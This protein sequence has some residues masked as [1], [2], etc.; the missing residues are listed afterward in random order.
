MKG[1]VFLTTIVLFAGTAA[2]LAQTKP[3]GPE[4]FYDEASQRFLIL[5]PQGFKKVQVVVRHP[6]GGRW[7]GDGE[8]QEKQILFAQT[9][10]EDQNRGTYFLAKGGESKWEIGFKPGQREPQDAGINGL[11]RRVSEEKRLQLARKEYQAAEATLDQSLK[12][13]A[14]AAVGP[15]KSLLGQWKDRWP[16]LRDRWVGLVFA[17][18]SAPKP[19]GQKPAPFGAKPEPP[20]QERQADYWFAMA[21]TASRA[22]G[23]V[24][25][26]LDKSRAV[27]W[28]GLYDDG[29]GGQINIRTDLSGKLRIT[30]NFSRG[31]DQ[32]TGALS[33]ETEPAKIITNKD[34]SK[35]AE[36]TAKDVAMAEGTTPA[37]A[38]V[39]LQRAGRFMIVETGNAQKIAG[40]GW[41]DGIYRWAP[42]PK[43]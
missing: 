39:K 29:F 15:D 43:E 13:A 12:A 35:S 14:K 18:P 41:F 3:V 27:D 20:G 36:I 23:F 22:M 9:V 4:H 37:V 28:D 17:M 21:E 8:K 34:G 7:V 30:L 11:Y 24:T 38:K 42:L 1:F 2:M 19:D 33:G 31:N 10:G 25:A 26:P 16:A 40:R 5:V 32:F 6:G